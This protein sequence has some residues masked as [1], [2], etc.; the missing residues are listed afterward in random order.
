MS[1]RDREEDMCGIQVSGLNWYAR[2]E[3]R[4]ALELYMGGVW[5]DD[6]QIMYRPKVCWEEAGFRLHPEAG[7][8]ASCARSEALNR[9][10][11]DVPPEHTLTTGCA[12]SEFESA[13]MRFVRNDRIWMLVVNFPERTLYFWKKA[14]QRGF[15]GIAAREKHSLD[16]GV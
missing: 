13:I 3:W 9:Q 6:N 10:M 5:S 15:L 16:Q 12:Q 1:V 14:N 2:H 8:Y 4:M 11:P 7:V